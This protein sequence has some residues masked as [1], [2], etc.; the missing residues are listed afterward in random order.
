MLGDMLAAEERWEQAAKEYEQAQIL[1]PARASAERKFGEMTLR[2]ADEIAMAK[3]GGAL[4]AGSSDSI[5][6]GAQGK[7]NPGFAMVLSL[8]VPGFG[9]FYN[10]QFI[11]GCICLGIFVVAMFL[12]SL[13]P[14][15]KALRCLF[16][17]TAGCR[18]LTISPLTWFC[19]LAASGAWL[20]SLVDAPIAASKTVDTSA[21]S[22]PVV[23]KSGWEV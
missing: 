1:D 12:V 22:G 5:T 23:D 7:R 9:Q 2:I 21:D 19:V 4:G 8:V 20:F 13:T 3:L 15:I 14:D 18:G 16:A 10:G 17:P 6:S 11:K